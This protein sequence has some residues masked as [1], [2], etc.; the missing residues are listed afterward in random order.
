MNRQISLVKSKGMQF[1]LPKD[2]AGQL[3]S[4]ERMKAALTNN[5]VLAFDIL[6]D[7]QVI[8]FA[9]MRYFK[10]NSWF[11]WNYAIDPAYQGQ[12]FGYAALNH[13]IHYMGQVHQMQLM[14]TTYLMGNRSAK[15]MY[16]KLGFIETDIV[17]QE[18]CQEVNMA[19][20]L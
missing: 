8:G 4:P 14:T 16:E 19:L 15:G 11:L 12:G 6:L 18:D 3:S 2:Q 9:M 7:E 20:T 13:I 5:D 10:V 1:Q 17:D